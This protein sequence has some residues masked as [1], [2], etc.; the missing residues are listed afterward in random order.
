[1]INIDT[2]AFTYTENKFW[3]LC[4]YFIM[5]TSQAMQRDYK[6]LQQQYNRF[7][8]GLFEAG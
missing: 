5:E 4:I 3:H 7:N 6:V 1:M 2:E 8:E